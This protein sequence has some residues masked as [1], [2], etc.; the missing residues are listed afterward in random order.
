[1][2]SKVLIASYV[3]KCSWMSIASCSQSA[4]CLKAVAGCVY[5]TWVCMDCT[6]SMP[7]QIENLIIL[8]DFDAKWRK[9][10]EVEEAV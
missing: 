4:Y 6:T 8:Q 1:M 9:Q 7:F 10:L 3:F 5:E 2:S